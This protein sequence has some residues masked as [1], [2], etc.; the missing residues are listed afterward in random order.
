MSAPATSPLP[1]QSRPSVPSSSLAPA[2]ITS[3]EIDLSCRGPLL[4]FFV[5]GMIWLVVGLLLALISSIK[6]HAPGLLSNFSWLTLGRI[7][8]AA[9]NA[10][11]Y[12]F[13]SQTALGVLLWMLCRLGRTR[14]VFQNTIAIAA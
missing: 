5:S 11:L 1:V 6:L 10:V 3:A 14:L 4:L 8:P 2:R 9:M 13:A 7:R 12:G